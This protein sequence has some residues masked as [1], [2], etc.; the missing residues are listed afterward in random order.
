MTA[1]HA[2]LPMAEDAPQ[3]ILVPAAGAGAGARR[4]VKPRRVGVRSAYNRSRRL[5]AGAGNLT[6]DKVLLVDIAAKLSCHFDNISADLF[7]NGELRQDG[8]PK[9]AMGRLLDLSEQ[10]RKILQPIF[11]ADDGSKW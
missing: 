4:H 10:I 6:P 11:G 1:S 9:V 8:E 5:Q 3:R 7:A 2:P